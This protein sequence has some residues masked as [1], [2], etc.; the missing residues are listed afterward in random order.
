M[1]PAPKEFVITGVDIPFFAVVGLIVKWS[2]A[3][4]PA[5]FLLWCLGVALTAL[6]G[7]AVAALMA[8]LGMASGAT[9]S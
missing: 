2:I 6:A 3:A 1:A 9:G 5:M 7:G 4:I 8:A